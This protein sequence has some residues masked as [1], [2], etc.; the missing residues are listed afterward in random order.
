VDTAAVLSTGQAHVLAAILPGVVIES[1]V[2]VHDVATAPEL[3]GAVA[4]AAAC[5]LP[6]SASDSAADASYM[7]ALPVPEEKNDD[8]S[9]WSSAACAS[10]VALS[11]AVV[12]A[13]VFAAPPDVPLLSPSAPPVPDPPPADVPCAPA[14]PPPAATPG[15]RAVESAG[16]AVAAAA[17]AFFA[18]GFGFALAFAFFFA[19]GHFAGIFTL[20]P[21]GIGAP[22]PTSGTDLLPTLTLSLRRPG[23][24]ASSSCSVR[25]YCL[26]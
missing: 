10:E 17:V 13:L 7:P 2:K 16:S 15:G 23:F 9:V 11:G 21:A 19:I 3:A 4:L 8:Q 24:A 26:A 12:L 6:L 25:P 1:P 20:V 22:E 14:V 18:A 5:S